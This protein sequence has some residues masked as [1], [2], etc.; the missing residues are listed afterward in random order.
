[1]EEKNGRKKTGEKKLGK[2]NPEKNPGNFLLENLP[3]NLFEN[4]SQ[5][6]KGP[7]NKA[8]KKAGISRAEYIS[9]FQRAHRLAGGKGAALHWRYMGQFI[10]AHLQARRPDHQGQGQA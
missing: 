8:D 5:E 6:N 9:L 2:I 7:E 1:M 4:Y 10:E 3:I